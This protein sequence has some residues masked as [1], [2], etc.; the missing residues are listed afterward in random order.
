M[1]A[2]LLDRVR[3]FG[4]D[5]GGP[6]PDETAEL[7]ALDLGPD[8]LDPDPQP[9]PE[10]RK[11]R[12][13][14]EVSAETAAKQPRAGGK[15]VS[16]ARQQQQLSDE[17]NMWLKM[18][19]GVWSISD[20]PCAAVLNATS[21]QIAEDLAKLGARSEWVMHHFQTTSLL[22]DAMKLIMHLWP[23]LRAVWQHHGSRAEP[24]EDFEPVEVDGPVDV[25]QYGPW[26][27]G[28]AA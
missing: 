11:R 16:T 23:L 1:T 7:P 19:A 28:N 6:A 3:F 4:G 8:G 2:S 21:A 27:P 18:L 24:D 12:P 17:L 5:G 25:G 26:R 22:G 15:F 9:A 14:S 13:K 10:T 20:E